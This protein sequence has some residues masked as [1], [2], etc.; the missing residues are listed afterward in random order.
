MD[1]RIFTV[2]IM[3]GNKVVEEIHNVF[4]INQRQACDNAWEAD[5]A[6]QYRDGKHE[7]RAYS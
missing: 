4:A 2:A 1:Y 5:I 6:Q 3:L 7:A